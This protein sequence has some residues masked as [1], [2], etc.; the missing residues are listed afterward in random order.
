MTN[1]PDVKIPPLNPPTTSND[2][3]NDDDDDEQPPYGFGVKGRSKS[4]K[5]VTLKKKKI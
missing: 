2:P 1:K 5:I 3:Q 4:V